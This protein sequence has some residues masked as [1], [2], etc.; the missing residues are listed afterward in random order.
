MNMKKTIDSTNETPTSYDFHKEFS[1][2]IFLSDFDTETCLYNRSSG[3]RQH[4]YTEQKN[5]ELYRQNNSHPMV[6]F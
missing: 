5:L 4:T 3:A 1:G 6:P 2:E